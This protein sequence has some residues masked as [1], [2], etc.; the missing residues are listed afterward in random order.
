MDDSSICAGAQ[1]TKY[2][3]KEQETE[4]K[5]FKDP[6]TNAD[7]DVTDKVGAPPACAAAFPILRRVVVRCS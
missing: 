2:L 7:L 5:H 1:E 3:T 4:S 6:A